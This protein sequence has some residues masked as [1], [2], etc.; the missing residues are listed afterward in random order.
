MKD[1]WVIFDLDGTLANIEE[2]RKLSTKDNGKM[3]WDKFFDPENIRLDKPNPAVIKMAQVLAESGHM[4]AILS[5]RSKG[6]QLTT[7]SWLNRNNVPYHIIKMRPTSKEWMYMP[8]DE[9]KQH[10]LDDLFPGDI[11]DRIVAVFDDRQKVVDMWRK[12]GL[13][14]MQVAP[15]D[16]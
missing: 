14:C 12:N 15:G 4:I 5:G 13:T 3:D 9:L 1:S 10:W 8:D 6:T 11:R 16:F 7:K 2:R